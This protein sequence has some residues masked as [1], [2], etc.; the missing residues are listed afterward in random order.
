MLT[1][2]LIA[3]NFTEMGIYILYIYTLTQ[4]EYLKAEVSRRIVTVRLKNSDPFAF[5]AATKAEA[6]ADMTD[7]ITAQQL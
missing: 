6:L 5:D 7:R 1:L 4:P 2:N 3:H